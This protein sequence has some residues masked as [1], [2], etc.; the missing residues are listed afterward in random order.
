MLPFSP[1]YPYNPAGGG[2]CLQGGE[3]VAI[4]K[5]TVY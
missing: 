5:D 4:I 2:F 3:T 1:I